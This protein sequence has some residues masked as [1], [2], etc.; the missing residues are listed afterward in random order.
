MMLKKKE[1]YF[2]AAKTWAD[3][4]YALAVASRNRYQKAFLSVLG[5]SALSIFAILFLLFRQQ[6][7]LIVV[8]EGVSGYE[9]ISSVKVGESPPASW[10]KTR[11]EI[12]RY[13]SSRESYDPIL[14][15]YQTKEVRLMSSSSVLSD[16]EST[17][18]AKDKDSPVNLLGTQGYRTVQILN[19]LSIDKIPKDPV[20][21][22][23]HENLA[24]VN[25]VREDHLLNRN[26]IIKKPYTAMISW[27]YR[28]LPKDPEQ[29][30]R[31][32][33]GFE[34]TKYEVQP[35]IENT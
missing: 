20:P 7:Q 33:D 34:V 31:N 9:W 30:F 16:Y 4:Y 15:G 3:D 25:F 24:Q 13:V 12:A 6:I 14:Y 28:G 1:D 11:A 23:H 21:G 5:L 32:W 2:E 35:V 18:D 8:H 17:Q 19:V 26:Q 29:W 27:K 22:I 10:L